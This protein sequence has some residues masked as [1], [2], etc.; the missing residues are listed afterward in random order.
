M[1]SP[2]WRIILAGLGQ[3]TKEGL[4]LPREKHVPM[5]TPWKL[6]PKWE[7]Y[8]YTPG[9]FAKSVEVADSA[10]VANVR[11]F[12][13]VQPIELKPVADPSEMKKA[14]VKALW[15]RSFD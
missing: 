9:V 13:S 7:A 3:G 4:R 8:G 11:D 10:R 5:P 12:E 14:P 15:R 6:V 1:A 2:E